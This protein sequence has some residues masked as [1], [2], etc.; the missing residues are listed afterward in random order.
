MRPHH[1]PLYALLLALAGCSS[2]LPSERAELG[3]EFKRYGDAMEA[4]QKV[5]ASHTTRSELYA[6]GFD[7]HKGGNGRFMSFIDVRTLFVQ[8]NVPLEYLPASLVHCLEAKERCTGLAFDYSQT[9]SKRVGN[10][11]ADAFNFR[12]KKEVHGWT[13][14]AVFVLIGDTIEHKMFT[15]EPRINRYEVQRNPLGPLQSVGDLISN[16]AK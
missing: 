12:K 6:L 15:G 5:D 10:F 4:F 13:F 1:L 8:E 3:T 7:P 11:W 2:M 9:D 16:Q 14:R